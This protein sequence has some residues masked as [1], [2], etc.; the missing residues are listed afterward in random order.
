MV[1]TSKDFLVA[2]GGMLFAL[3]TIT[4]FFFGEFLNVNMLVEI[5]CDL[6][7]NEMPVS[8]VKSAKMRS[9]N[10]RG[11]DFSFQ[12][13]EIQKEESSQIQREGGS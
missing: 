2:F 12:D 1:Y 7:K 6:Y 13:L 3:N 8:F 11:S 9:G 5:M 10:K 4:T